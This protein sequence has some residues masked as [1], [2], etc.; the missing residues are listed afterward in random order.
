MKILYL[1]LD[2][3]PC[4]FSYPQQIAR[5]QPQIDLRVPPLEYLGQKKRPAD[6][7][8]LWNWLQKQ[9]SDCHY[10]I[11]SIEMLVYGGLL[12]SR[13]HHHSIDHLLSCLEPLKA[14]KAKQPELKLFA[15]N[16]IMR[17]PSYSS[18]EEEPDY[19]ADFGA[20]IFRWGWLTDRGD[21]LPLPPEE[22]QELQQLTAQLPA[23][24][25]ADY[26]QRR[27]KNLAV[28]QA[29]IDL[30]QAGVIDFLAIP[31]DDSAPYGLTAIDQQ[32]I[33]RKISDLRLQRQVH[34]YPGADEV[35]CT[36][37]ARAYT[38]Q[39][40]LQPRFYPLY[41]SVCAEQIVPLYEDRPL[42]ESLRSHLLAAG[43]QLAPTPAQADCILALNSPGQVMQEAWDQD[44]KD[45]TYS[46]YRNLRFFVSQIE[47]YL[48]AGQ[49]VA[50]ADVAFANG[51]ETEL[52]Q[53]LDDAQLW[54]GLLAYGG[55]NT[56]C[57]TIGTV[58]ATAILGWKG[59]EGE[60]IAFNKI[61]HLLEDWAYQSVV[62]GAMVQ[63]YLPTLGASYY[64]FNQQAPA[65]HQEIARQIQA[66]WQRT[67]RHSFG[68]WRI[69]DLTVASPWQRMFEI[70]LNLVI[71]P[72]IRT[73]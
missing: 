8:R 39:Q 37:L 26:Q 10:A 14:I 58:L 73:P 36:L 60:A 17:T 65:I 59:G 27:A 33:V 54:D 3:R 25:L 62:R 11:L 24:V 35:G 64:D 44:Q 68:A 4:N 57:N 19:Y 50:V 9:F 71:Q 5:L 69:E 6:R 63:N 45:M 66:V 34:L 49:A 23:D 38:Q 43:A 70:G 16:L 15:S 22:T 56:S 7:D 51:G 72:T 29:T 31:Q 20:Q 21:R 46:S 53:L 55:W 42:G 1:P 13:L 61:H 48:G 32:Q 47:A 12:P 2:E 41:S 30:V 40:R 52:V 28:N 67:M 18:S